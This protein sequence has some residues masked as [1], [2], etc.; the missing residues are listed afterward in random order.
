[1]RIQTPTLVVLGL[2]ALLVAAAW[3]WERHQAQREAVAVL[4]EEVA[5]LQ[6][7][8]ESRLASSLGP[9]EGIAMMIS[10]DDVPASRVLERIGPRLVRRDPLLI[11]LALAPDLVIRDVFPLDPNREAIGVD[12]RM[13]P[14]DLA[15]VRAFQSREAVLAGP[16]RLR[17]GNMA[18]AI[19]VPYERSGVDGQTDSGLV[20][21]AIDFHALM[22]ASGFEAFSKRHRSTLIALESDENP[23]SVIWGDIDLADDA[24]IIRDV[25]VPGGRW[26]WRVDRQPRVPVPLWSPALSWG[27]PF[28]AFLAG[29]AQ[30]VS[31]RRSR[32][33]RAAPTGRA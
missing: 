11:S 16:F 22:A 12:F 20:S 14:V 21:I 30:W 3:G 7:R 19:R 2:C 4:A 5:T 15:A 26:L 23:R 1:M 32:E 29:L 18:L 10:A 28:A 33:S 25:V 8:L 6:Q 13:P 31:S 9:V 27:V 24:P 17:Q